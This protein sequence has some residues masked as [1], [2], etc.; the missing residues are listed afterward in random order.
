M[1]RETEICITQPVPVDTPF[2]KSLVGRMTFTEDLFKAAAELLG[3]PVVDSDYIYTGDLIHLG[4]LAWELLQNRIGGSGR[5]GTRAFRRGWAGSLSVT[6]TEDGGP[7]QRD[8][9]CEYPVSYAIVH[10]RSR[11]D[12]AHDRLIRGVCTW[13][14]ERGVSWAW[15]TDDSAPQTTLDTLVQAQWLPWRRTWYGKGEVTR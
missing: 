5:R 2:V 1:S 4:C 6:W 9:E 14:D 7:I 8:P 3:P 13:L 10:T 11:D 15:Q 12:A